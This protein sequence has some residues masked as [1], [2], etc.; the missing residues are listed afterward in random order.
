M[1]VVAADVGDDVPNWLRHFPQ[2]AVHAAIPPEE[3]ADEGPAALG[4]VGNLDAV[5]CDG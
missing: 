1:L 2:A 4:I 5:E 3:M